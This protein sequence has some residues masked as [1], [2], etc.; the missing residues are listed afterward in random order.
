VVKLKLEREIP[1]DVRGEETNARIEALARRH[2]AA[3]G[4]GGAPRADLRSSLTLPLRLVNA[5]G[6]SAARCRAL[7]RRRRVSVFLRPRSTGG[8]PRQTED[9]PIDTHRGGAGG[10]DP[11]R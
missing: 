4:A 5:T 9:R 2:L 3:T 11:T 10:F 6:F 8:A 1:D 7:C